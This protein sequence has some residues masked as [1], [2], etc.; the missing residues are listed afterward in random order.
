MVGTGAASRWH[1]LRAML[2]IRHGPGAAVIPPTVTRIHVEFAKTYNNG[3]MGPRRFWRDM[4][5]RLKFHNPS[6]PM[7]VNRKDSNEG[8]AL[9]SIYLSD[10]AAAGAEPAVR[11]QPPSSG[12]DTSKAAPPAADERVVK[13]DMKNQRSEEILAR[14]LAETGAQPVLPTPEEQAEMKEVE[15][16]ERQGAVD[17]KKQKATIDERNRERDLLKKARESVID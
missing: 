16:M 6:I 15:E 5:P 7:I 14:F 1:K 11:I 9:L 4:L 13:I 2:R 17:R 12:I 8:P 10:A 3:H